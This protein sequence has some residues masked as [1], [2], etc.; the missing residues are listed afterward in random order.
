MP[1]SHPGLI[2]GQKNDPTLPLRALKIYPLDA[3]TRPQGKYT[4]RIALS[5]EVKLWERPDVD[6]V[7][8][9]GRIYGSTL[10]L[11]ETSIEE[12]ALS[13][14]RISQQLAQIELNG[15]AAE[16]ESNEK[17]RVIREALAADDAERERLRKIAADATFE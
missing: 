14:A 8:P 17:A 3:D 15:M 2:T 1:E 9:N 11:N 13:T 16:A 12:V 7:I 5:R 4:V 10:E 6:A